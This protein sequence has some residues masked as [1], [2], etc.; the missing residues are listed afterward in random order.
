MHQGDQVILAHVRSVFK[1]EFRL[2]PAMRNWRAQ[3]LLNLMMAMLDSS[4]AASSPA[5]QVTKSEYGFGHQ[6]NVCWNTHHEQLHTL[7]GFCHKCGVLLPWLPIPPASPEQQ[8]RPPRCISQPF[9]HIFR[10][11]ADCRTCQGNHA[12]GRSPGPP[13][14]CITQKR[15]REPVQDV[16]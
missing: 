12:N 3:C 1:A 13:S 9:Q 16:N 15:L 10:G 11:A 2:E 4:E 5:I 14:F 6:L 8:A 7:T